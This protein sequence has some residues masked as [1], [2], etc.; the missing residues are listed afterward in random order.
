[1]LR[2][3]AVTL[4]GRLSDI[5]AEANSGQFIHLLGSNGA[6]KSSLLAAVAGLVQVNKGRIE[7]LR[8][9][10]NEFS[11]AQLAQFRC[12]QEQQQNSA[13]AITVQESLSFFTGH[14][15]LPAELNHALEVDKF[16]QRPLGRLS[17]GESRRVHIARCLLQIWSAIVQG[18]ALI[19]LDEPVQ[20]LDFRHQHL[21]CLLLQA[22][23]AKGNLILMSHHDLNLSQQYASHVWLMRDGRLIEQGE[24]DD[25]LQQKLLENAFEC[26]VR[27]LPDVDNH[28][29][30][31]TYLA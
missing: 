20:G 8:Q 3:K 21:L 1:M 13:F 19:L 17:G 15:E 22:L 30:F 18:Q 4:D 24:R 9:G 29:L 23:A 31:Q 12:L 2:L 11:L 26:R 10:I 25:I 5:S 16:L 6:G 28:K 14:S 27:L 7:I